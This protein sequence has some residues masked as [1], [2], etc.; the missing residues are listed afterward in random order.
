MCCLVGLPEQWPAN[1]WRHDTIEMEWLER[2]III[3]LETW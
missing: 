1:Q 3:A 2:M